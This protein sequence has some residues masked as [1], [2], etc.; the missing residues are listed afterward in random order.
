MRILA[1]DPGYIASASLVYLTGSKTITEARLQTNGSLLESLGGLRDQTDLL[2]IEMIASYG[3]PVGR[4]VFETC[5][6]VGKFIERYHRASVH[7]YRKDVKMHL[8]HT[9][10]AKDSNVRQALI[11][12]FGGEN[13]AIGN[14][15]CPK[16]KAKGWFGAGRTVC[17]K[18][19]GRKWKYPPGPLADLHDDLWAA[20]AIAVTAAD[21]NA[22]E[23][24]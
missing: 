22:S 23:T 4:E 3:M 13:A 1:I 18:C 5:V 17:P 8:C 14:K 11:D 9:M 16:C 7:V 20:L 10:R 19:E 21:L 12:R 6:W 2:A 15:K 24:T